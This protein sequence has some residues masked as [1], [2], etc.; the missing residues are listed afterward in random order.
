MEPDLRVLLCACTALLWAGRVLLPFSRPFGRHPRCQDARWTDCIISHSSARLMVP[1]PP[2]PPPPPML[3]PGGRAARVRRLQDWQ[4]GLRRCSAGNARGQG[5]GAGA[6]GHAA[7]RSDGIRVAA[8]AGEGG[9]D[10]SGVLAVHV[11]K[12]V[13]GT[14]GAAGDAALPA[15][16]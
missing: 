1:S 12:A 3:L 13:D 5:G 8:G 6:A 4:G 11:D 2:P 10:V 15:P 7:L 14:R 9:R 16:C